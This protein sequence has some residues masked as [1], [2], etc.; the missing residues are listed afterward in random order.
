MRVRPVDVGRP[1]VTERPFG[2]E[3]CCGQHLWRVITRDIEVNLQ[4]GE[5]FLEV[6]KRLRMHAHPR[7]IRRAHEQGAFIHTERTLRD[8]WKGPNGHP[9][10]TEA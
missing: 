4:L 5:P 7:T 1:T 9:C 3:I 2:S 8:P 6:G 10:Q